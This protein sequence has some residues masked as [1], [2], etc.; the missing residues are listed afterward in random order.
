MSQTREEM[1]VLAGEI[2]RCRRIL[3]AIGDE[4]RQHL[5]LE[6]LDI[7]NVNG[8]R[9][10]EIVEK[11]HLSRPAVSHHLK[12]L[13]DVGIVRMRK[14]GTKNFYYFDSHTEAMKELIDMLEHAKK[15]MEYLQ[16]KNEEAKWLESSEHR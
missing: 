11:T 12:V 4:N 6:M 7:G 3:S 10:G 8:M 14:E 2:D 16:S 15:L 13:K 1:K 9:V 5:I